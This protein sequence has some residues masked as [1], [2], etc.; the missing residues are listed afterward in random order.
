MTI[1][2]LFHQWLEGL[3]VV[4]PGL[5]FAMVFVAY[6]RITLRDVRI[7]RLHV[8]L[9][10]IQFSASTVVYLATIKLNPLWAEAFYISIL[11]PTAASAAVIT[12]MLGG[13]LG[14]LA[15][16][17]LIGNLAAG[18]LVPVL[19][20][21]LG[22]QSTMPF[23]D[24][25]LLMFR[26]IFPLLILPFLLG[27]VLHKLWPSA[28]QA[29]RNHPEY[30]FYIWTISLALVTARTVHFLV[31]HGRAHLFDVA[32]LASGSLLICVAQFVLGR[33][34]GAKW[35]DKISGGQALGQK[36]TVLAIWLAQTYMHPL[37]SIAPASY[38]LW[39]NSIN[40][41]QLWRHRHK[42]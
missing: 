13:N 16:Y 39:Q 15:T 35:G 6:C 3:A 9:L 24:S 30:S 17:T 27:V 21:I 29:V 28:H 36:N 19:F 32:V 34:L 2:T 10:A 11:A 20:P 8:V 7:T 42:N 41:L 5:L 33:R 12:A 22:I 1:G 31:I 25:F 40:T 4:M 23:A 14:F 38:I 37:A 26:Q 18:L